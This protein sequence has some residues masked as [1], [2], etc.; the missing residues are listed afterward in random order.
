LAMAA[1]KCGTRETKSPEIRPGFAQGNE[2]RNA[3]AK[4]A[5][6]RRGVASRQGMSKTRNVAGPIT[7]VRLH[8]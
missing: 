6:P 2:P 5:Y 4:E 8:F 3:S 7:V 1:A